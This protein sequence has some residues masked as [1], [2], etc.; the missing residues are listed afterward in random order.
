MPFS[1]TRPAGHPDFEFADAENSDLAY[2]R[3]V[4]RAWQEDFPGLDF[5]GHGSENEVLRV[6]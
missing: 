4:C 2:V 3:K 6:T 1:E 5:Q